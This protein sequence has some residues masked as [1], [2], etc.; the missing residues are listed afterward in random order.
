MESNEQVLVAAD[1]AMIIRHIS[2]AQERLAVLAPAVSMDVGRAICDRWIALGPDRVSVTL[3]VDPEVYRLGY[4]DES[5]LTLLE[6][7]G[8]E[9]GSLL[10][11]QPG[12]R[13]GV[14][15]ADESVLIFAPVPELI[16][17]GPRSPK[18]PTGVLLTKSI[19][20]VDDAL[21]V[22]GGGVLLQEVGLDKA[23]RTDIE[24]VKEDLAKNPPQKFDVVRKLRVFNAAFQFVELSITGTQI[25]RRK[26]KI[27]N[28]LLGVA[29]GRVQKELTAALRI[30]P[31]NH[32]LSGESLWKKRQRIEKRHLRTISGY[33]QAVLRAEKDAFIRA[34]EDLEAEV[35]KFRA[36]L[37][38]R[39]AE[40][41][42][43]RI[44]HLKEALLPRLK[45]SPPDE[46]IIPEDPEQ[47]EA[48]IKRC[49]GEDLRDAI[50]SVA[51]YTG[52]I[53]VK[54]VF[55]DVTYESLGDPAFRAA[56][57]KAFP[58]LRDRLHTE[59]DAAAAV[60]TS[61]QPE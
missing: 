42:D 44:E 9:V 43:A 53:D 30:V 26:V 10:Q 20:V 39:L 40:E 19:P 7:T 60:P 56:A 11:C 25:Q 41:L 57:A 46:W 28:Y 47:R 18:Q 29:D 59:Q 37:T 13:I 31:E 52:E 1:A 12:I 48:E 35:E 61:L 17:A 38:E 4:G 50:G 51:Q 49:L 33:G 36:L 8:Q 55:R 21:G 6:E 23:T 16:E 5:A 15:V 22:G 14:I 3:D 34:I 45:E 27:P 2:S 54:L 24:E 32:E 58:E